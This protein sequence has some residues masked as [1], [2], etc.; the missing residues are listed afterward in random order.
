M[1][2]LYLGLMS[3]TSQDGVDAA[4]VTLDSRGYEIHGTSTTPYPASIRQR[5][6]TL[7]ANS[8]VSLEELGG[9]DVA[10][11][12]F[13]ADCALR[14]LDESGHDPGSVAG[15]GHSGH[16]VFHRPDGQEAFTLQLGDP[17]TVAARTGITTVGHL[18]QMDIALGGQGAPLAPA[19]HQW[20]FA[21]PG[22][23]RAV[24]NIGGIANVSILV[25]GRAPLGFDTGPGNT[26]LDRWAQRCIGRP[27]DHDGAW[28]RTG[29]V[30][31]G[32]LDEM[33]SDPFFRLPAPKSTGLEHF[34]LDWL[35]AALERTTERPCDADVQATLVELTAATIA[36]AT[37]DA[38]RRPHRVILCG[39]GARN[40]ALRQ[41]LAAHLEGIPV[42]SSGHHGIE[43][44]WVEAVLFAWLSRAR[45]RGETGNVPAVT[46]ARRAAMLGGVY[47]GG[48]P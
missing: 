22:E 34:N 41:R 33:R 16:T 3:G 46:G 36:L 15:I 2:R 48:R 1:G 43:P 32:L 24:V 17:S 21:D 10:I 39:G 20:A 47:Y 29:H 4:L 28:S 7:L 11:A 45:L 38:G 13:F 14:L 26:L 30:H 40:G 23:R 19:F 35:K 9:L 5:I 8:T 44:E 18:R 37:R 42:E 27:Y 31:S 6:E 12:R 25:S